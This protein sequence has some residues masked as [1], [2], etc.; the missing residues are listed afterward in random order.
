MSNMSEDF[1]FY[2]LIK[3]VSSV[4]F[5]LYSKY[6]LCLTFLLSLEVLLFLTA[7][8][9]RERPN[10]GLAYTSFACD[11]LWYVSYL[12]LGTLSLIGYQ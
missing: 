9:D 1:R 12:I 8:R 3:L 10:L 5:L 2:W 11:V 6:A 7:F 4:M